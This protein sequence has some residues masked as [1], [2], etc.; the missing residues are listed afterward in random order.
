LLPGTCLPD[1]IVPVSSTL[2]LFLLRPPLPH[3]LSRMPRLPLLPLPPGIIT[4]ATPVPMPSPSCRVAQLSLALGAEMIPCVMP[5]SLIDTSDCPFLPPL[6][7]P[8]SSLTSYTVTFEP[9]LFQVSLVT[10]ITWSS[11]MT[12]PTIYRL[13]C[14][15]RSP[16][17]SRLS[18]TSSP[19]CPC[20]LATPSEVSS[21]IM[22][23]NLITPPPTLSS[24][25]DV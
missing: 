25:H 15:A 21:V 8:F 16:T 14:C 17:P 12:A 23:V 20:S 6:L 22:G 13:F 1:T 7:E 3:V 10:S 24:S 18:P 11:S 5:A 19:L 2:Y 9:L 4:L